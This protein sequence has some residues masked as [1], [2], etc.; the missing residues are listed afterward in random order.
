MARGAEMYDLLMAMR[1]DRE[2]ARD[3]GAWSFLCRM[4]SEFKRLDQRDREGRR[5]WDPPA[6]VKARHPRLAATV[7]GLNVAGGRRDV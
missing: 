1:F 4:A 2:A 7:V 5:S 3:A 6:T